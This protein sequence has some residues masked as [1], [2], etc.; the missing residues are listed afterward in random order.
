MK[1]MTRSV[2]LSNKTAFVSHVLLLQIHDWLQI[3]KR[4]RQ[5]HLMKEYVAKDLPIATVLNDATE[6]LKVRAPLY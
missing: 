2:V 1:M 4:A 5:Q 6:A 3:I